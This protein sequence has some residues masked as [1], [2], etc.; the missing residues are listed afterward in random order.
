MYL[1]RLYKSSKSFTSYGGAESFQFFPQ[2]LGH[3]LHPAIGQISHSARCV[4]SLCHLL[5]RVAKTN[6]LH[7][8]AINDGQA[9]AFGDWF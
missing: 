6:P 7:P 1:L 3:Q 5:Y 8:S 9:A 2:P 4:K